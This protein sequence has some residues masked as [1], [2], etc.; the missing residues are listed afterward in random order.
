MSIPV[1]FCDDDT[2][3]NLNGCGGYKNLYI[4]VKV[5]YNYAYTLYQY[6][7]LILILTIVIQDVITRE[8]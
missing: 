5:G 1:V 6:K 2:V 3:L 4:C 7:F 8:D